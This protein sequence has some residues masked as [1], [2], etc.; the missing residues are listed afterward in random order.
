MKISGQRFDAHGFEH[1]ASETLGHHAGADAISCRVDVRRSAGRADAGIVY[2]SDVWNRD[3]GNIRIAH[4]VSP[5]DG[6]RIVYPA[7]AIT[8]GRVPLARELIAF[9]RSARAQQILT[10]AGFRALDD[11]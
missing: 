6:P 9:L 1:L 8:G 3:R 7:A 2:L 4:R 11:R 10:A 5:A